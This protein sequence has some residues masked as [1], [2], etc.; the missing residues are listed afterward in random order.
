MSK[1]PVEIPLGA[2]RFNSDLQKL[3]YFNGE[4]WMQIHTVPNSPIA[5]SGFFQ[6]G[7]IS[8]SGGNHIE[9]VTIATTG[10]AVD[11]GDLPTA[12]TGGGAAG[13]SFTRAV[14]G[15]GA[16]TSAPWAPKNH[17]SSWIMATAGNGVDWGDLTRDSYRIGAGNAGDNT[18]VCFVGGINPGKVDTIDYVTIESSGG[19]IDFGNLGATWELAAVGSNATRALCGGGNRT[20]ASNVDTIEYITIQSTGNAVDFGNLTVGRSA[21]AGLSNSTR[22]FVGGG[23][24][25]P[26]YSNTIDYVTTAS[27]GNAADFGDLTRVYSN[28]CG[29]NST[30]RGLFGGGYTSVPSG[31]SL[32][33]ISYIDLTSRGD[34]HNFGDLSGTTTNTRA[35]SNC[36]GGLG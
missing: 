24:I 14:H 4:I 26:T 16:L 7:A 5:A 27:L 20:P 28:L 6:G 23:L 32:D 18:R 11:F 8:T 15:G 29:A 31:T 9:Y 33:I 21:C 35:V 2:M 3:E 22:F 13:A 30:V 17:I 1:P 12:E 36:H 34:A 10:D 19:A 25:S